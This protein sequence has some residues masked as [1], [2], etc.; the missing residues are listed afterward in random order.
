L[1]LWNLVLTGYPSSGKTLLA[2]KIVQERSN[3]ARI[4]GDDLRTMLFNEQI[5]S[6]D[7]ELLYS[8][9][10]ITRDELLRRQYNVII[11]TT[12]PTNR[13]RSHFMRTKVPNVDSLLIVVVAS[14]NS[15]LERTR[16]RGHF[17]AVEAWDK[18]WEPPAS[19]TP[20]FKFRND[21]LEEFNTNYYVVSE[22]LNSRIHP[23]RRRFL[24]NRFPR[25]HG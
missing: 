7:E 25:V 15:L 23:Y 17:G 4:S 1:S 16:A 5:P 13:T 18:S 14:R 22:L 11:D 10:T 12:A 9:L 19:N 6:R 24:S 3:F 21:N 8:T 20:R 2:R